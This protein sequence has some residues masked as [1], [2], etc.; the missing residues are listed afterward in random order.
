MPW[1]TNGPNHGKF[2]AQKVFW[3]TGSTEVDEEV[4]LNDNVTEK[5][6]KFSYLGDVLISRGKNIN[7]KKV[8]RYSK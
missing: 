7:W 4:A 1:K 3:F 2:F 8:R 6:E 5:V